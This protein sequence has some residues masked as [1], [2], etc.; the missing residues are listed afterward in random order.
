MPS[1]PA[2][3]ADVTS[4]KLEDG[5]HINLEKWTDTT[6]DSR[7]RVIDV[8]PPLT[9][10]KVAPSSV[11]DAYPDHRVDCPAHGNGLV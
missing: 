6:G 8:G 1:C 10:A 2:C 7:Y 9:V 4:A 3:G 5:T 11:V